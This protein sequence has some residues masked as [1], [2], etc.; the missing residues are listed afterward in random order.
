MGDFI[1]FGCRSGRCGVC[2]IRVLSGGDTLSPRTAKEEQLLAMLGVEDP[3]VRLACQ[4]RAH[5][6]IE[7]VEIY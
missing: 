2:A 5:G 6:D 4:S 3:A 7:L 1:T